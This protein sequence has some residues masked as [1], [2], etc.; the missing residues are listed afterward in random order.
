MKFKTSIET[1]CTLLFLARNTLMHQHIII[2]MEQGK[3]A[4]LD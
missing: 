3:S 1:L 4:T 2:H